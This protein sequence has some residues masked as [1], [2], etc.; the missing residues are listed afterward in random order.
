MAIVART[1]VTTIIKSVVAHDVT[2]GQA[3]LSAQTTVLCATGVG[4]ECH[5][6]LPKH[7]NSNASQTHLS[8]QEAA[9]LVSHPYSCSR[10][11]I[12]SL[13][14]SYFIHVRARTHGPWPWPWPCPRAR[15][16][17]LAHEAIFAACLLQ[18]RLHNYKCTLLPRIMMHG[19][20]PRALRTLIRETRAA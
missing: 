15:V 5:R 4:S 7:F 11:G 13:P 8:A 3:P 17:S 12:Q 14:V 10:I 2:Q 9:S 1:Q 18:H 20:L 16:A 6:D 19:T